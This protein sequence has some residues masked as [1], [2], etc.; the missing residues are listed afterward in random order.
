MFFFFW[1][2]CFF[3]SSPFIFN[4]AYFRFASLK[5]LKIL[6]FLKILFLSKIK[7]EN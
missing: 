4:L 5:K 3:L 1:S 2:R 7:I 6:D